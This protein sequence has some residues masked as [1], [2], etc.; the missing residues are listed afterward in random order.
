MAFLY[1]EQISCM[2]ILYCKP[3]KP[4][5]FVQSGFFLMTCGISLLM[6]GPIFCDHIELTHLIVVFPWSACRARGI[7]RDL[8]QTIKAWLVIYM[9]KKSMFQKNRT[10]P[11]LTRDSGNFLQ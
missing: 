8:S 11:G 1:R 6:H 5:S 9:F 7:G 10:T 4:P 2:V 3:L